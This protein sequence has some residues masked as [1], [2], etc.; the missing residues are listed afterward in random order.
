MLAGLVVLV[1]DFWKICLIRDKV[2]VVSEVNH[3][4]LVGGIKITMT[5]IM[6]TDKVEAVDGMVDSK[7]PRKS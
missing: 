6:V 5:I 2:S 3:E 1:G 7:L 4:V